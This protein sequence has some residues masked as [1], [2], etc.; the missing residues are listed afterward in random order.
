M[1]DPCDPWFSVE[2]QPPFAYFYQNWLPRVAVVSLLAWAVVSEFLHLYPPVG[3]Y[4]A[5]VAVGG[6]VITIWPPEKPWSKAVWLG[7]FLFL[8]V[9]EI[10]NLYRDRAYHDNEQAQARAQELNSFNQIAFGINQS[11][12]TGQQQ[13]AANS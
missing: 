2:K 7:I 6:V 8:G 3:T 5:I 4:I 12:A 11:I 10:R 9:F 1:D 13:F